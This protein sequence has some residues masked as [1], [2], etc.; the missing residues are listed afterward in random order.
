MHT[1]PGLYSTSSASVITHLKSFF[2]RHG[3]PETVM[4]DNGPQY[5]SK[6][7]AAFA[8]EQGFIHA[9][10]SPNH[11]SANG[12]AERAVRTVKQLLESADD[13]YDALLCYRSTPQ[14]NG[15][16]PAEMLM[17][18][19]LRT[20]L[21]MASQ[22]RIPAVPNRSSLAER[23]NIAREKHKNNF[24]TR[25]KARTLS[26]LYP[27]DVVFIKDRRERGRSLNNVW[28]KGRIW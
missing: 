13:P 20:K 10:S 7:F 3:I 9:T 12:S 22:Q 17:N 18:R 5:A 28:A 23:E 8:A 15:Y 26:T 11:P 14:A 27:G 21:P 25:H 4:S 19:K 2:A 6:E 24:D 1:A 16:S